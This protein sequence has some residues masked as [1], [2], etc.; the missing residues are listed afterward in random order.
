MRPIVK[1]AVMHCASLM[2]VCTRGNLAAVLAASVLPTT[3][4]AESAAVSPVIHTAA[5]TPAATPVANSAARCQP[6]PLVI[7][8][9]GASGYRPEHSQMAYELALQQG[10]D[11][12]ELDLVVSQDGQLVIR[13]E[14]ELS[15]S[16]NIADIASFKAR[17]TRKQIDGLWVEGW[18]AE[19][20]TWAELQTLK[21]R[22]SKAAQRPTNTRFND[23][24]ALWRLQDFLQ[25]LKT[26]AIQAQAFDIYIELKHPYYFS[27][28]RTAAAAQGYDMAALLAAQLDAEALRLPTAQTA[29]KHINT[30]N[31]TA[32][33]YRHIYLQAF[34]PTVLRQWQQQH[35]AKVDYDV[36][37]VQLLGDLTAAS[38][39]PKDNFSHP[40]DWVALAA[41]QQHAQSPTPRH[42]AVPALAFADPKMPDYA[43]LVTPA[44][45]RFMKSYAD[46]LGPWYPQVTNA[47]HGQLQDW[48]RMAKAEGFKIHPYTLR[49]GE[50]FLRKNQQGQT[51]SMQQELTWL[52]QQGI[53]GVFADEPDK[54][55]ETRQRLCQR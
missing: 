16:T 51:I 5:A 8:H 24:A 52:F 35:A 9:R 12:L 40:Y 23:Q 22:E 42:L 49:D 28:L 36:T 2:V 30:N 4:L 44:G 54:A 18:F 20:F 32:K 6:W 50:S 29:G 33:V 39:L 17:K 14:N 47:E 1:N 37:V 41:A 25:W 3:V 7:A 34:E 38:R 45:L 15:L 53:D 19:D 46:A 11:V 10:A 48:V 21:L 55:I 27:S 43:A 26:P 13:H 31:S